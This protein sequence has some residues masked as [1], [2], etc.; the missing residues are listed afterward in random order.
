MAMVETGDPDTSRMLAGQ[1]FADDDLQAG[2]RHA[3]AA[4]RGYR[5]QGDLPSAARMAIDLASL[6]ASSLGNRAAAQGWLE[7]ARRTLE[8][9]GPCVEW[10]YLELAFMACDRPD[11]IELERSAQRA[12]DIALE[13]GDH[14]L[15]VRALADGGLALITQGKVH[16]GFA[17]LDAAMT[18]LTAGEVQDP[19]IAGK[20][21]CSLLSGC[22]RA[23]DIARAEEWTRIIGEMVTGPTGGRPVVLVTHCLLA[24]GSVLAAAGRWDEA[25]T[26]MTTALGPTASKSLGHRI[27]ITCNLARIRAEQGRLEEAAALLAP[28]EDQVAA[29]E[30]A[31]LVHLRTG[32]AALAAAIAR[33]GLKELAG[34]A[35]RGGALLTRLVEAEI[36]LG[37]LD[38]AAASANSLSALAAAAESVPIA[39]QAGLCHGRVAMARGNHTGA[40]AELEAVC[41]LLST[42]TWPLLMGTARTELAEALAAQ[43]DTPAAIGEARAAAAIFER[44]GARAGT[45]RVAALLRSLGATAPARSRDGQDRAVGSLSAREAEV[46][47]LI[48]AGHTNAEIAKRLYIS[49]KTAEHH[50]SRVLSKLGVRTRAEAA[51]LAAAR[52]SSP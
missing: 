36:A 50:V 29:C 20:S 24:Y 28:Y 12:L 46:L 2:R 31:A 38:A 34:D 1:A 37:D 13:F 33:R 44:L 22:D 40:V 8:K 6:H 3:E 41:A 7:R 51:A 16:E 45:D 27:E 48:Q 42:G 49:P 47:S 26:V 52:P 35:L 9:V 14:D 18:A 4:F 43:G 21:F 32:D 17:R 19:G 5:D 30:P 11:A 39:A 15:E 25:D 23:G 10:G